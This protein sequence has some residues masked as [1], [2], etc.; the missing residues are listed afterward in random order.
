MSDI[1]AFLNPS[2]GMLASHTALLHND[3]L[4]LDEERRNLQ[5]TLNRQQTALDAAIA[6]KRRIEKYLDGDE[7]EDGDL[8]PLERKIYLLKNEVTILNFTVEIY[9]LTYKPGKT[10]LEKQLLVNLWGDLKQT[11]QTDKMKKV[12]DHLSAQLAP[13]QK[14]KEIWGDLI[15]ITCYGPV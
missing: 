7:D 10:D 1:P 3:W 14:Q 12:L 4:E 15:V 8:P 5:A 13:D 2:N 9:D 6:D 11:F